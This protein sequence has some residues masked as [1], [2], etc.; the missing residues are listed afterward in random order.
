[1]SNTDYFTDRLTALDENEMQMFRFLL[2]KTSGAILSAETD[3]MLA[4]LLA[5]YDLLMMQDGNV[6]IIPEGVRNAYEEVW[7]DE[8]ELRWKKRN[9]MY[10]CLEAAMDLYGVMGLKELHALFRLRYPDADETETKELFDST[11]AAYQ[12]FREIDGRLVLNGFDKDDYYKYLEEKVQRNVSFYVPSAEE[13]D[14]LYDQGCLVSR[15]AHAKLLDFITDTFGCDRN[16]ATVKL[17]QLYRSVNDHMGVSDA[18]EMFAAAEED[19]SAPFAFPSDEVEVKFIE[20]YMEMSRECR[21]R[22]N[23][24]HDYY[25]MVAVMAEKNLRGAGSASVS[26]SGKKSAPVKRV[27]IGRNDPCPCGSG[28]KYKNCCMNRQLS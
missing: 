1:M 27:K 28:K 21:M 5:S 22:D 12:W 26:G 18:A 8:L 23:R 2:D 16:A 11:P 25:E 20:L 15:E 6:V 4:K 19:G 13:V 17:A 24:G 10:R 14:E 9:W 3:I 7:S